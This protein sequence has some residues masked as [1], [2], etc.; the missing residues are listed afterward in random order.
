[1][2]NWQVRH[3]INT[4]CPHSGWSFEEISSD[5]SELSDTDRE[6]PHD[7][8]PSS[9]TSDEEHL[10]SDGTL[11]RTNGNDDYLWIRDRGTEFIYRK[12]EIPGGYNLCQR[13]AVRDA[14]LRPL[15]PQNNG[16]W[17]PIGD[18]TEHLAAGMS[19]PCCVSHPV[20]F[21]NY[22]ITGPCRACNSMISCGLL[23]GGKCEGS[24]YLKKYV[25][26]EVT[27]IHEKK[28]C[29]PNITFPG[30]ISREWLHYLACPRDQY[31]QPGADV[32]VEEEAYLELLKFCSVQT[33]YELLC[34]KFNFAGRLLRSKHPPASSAVCCMALH[35][36]GDG[37]SVQPAVRPRQKPL[38]LKPEFQKDDDDVAGHWKHLPLAKIRAADPTV[39][40]RLAESAVNTLRRWPRARNASS[41]TEARLAKL[42]DTWMVLPSETTGKF[43]SRSRCLARIAKLFND[44]TIPDGTAWE[45]GDCGQAIPPYGYSG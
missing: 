16:I 37:V 34:C 13:R 42:L 3:R 5:E 7:Y 15:R 29:A 26:D 10:E 8:P 20:R 32:G 11:V 14:T 45:Y 17:M 6:Y 41:R 36:N 31:Y 30:R 21:L 24:K 4:T 40:Y 43:F 22:G 1:M 19:L 39:L 35:W 33:D 23:F 28:S 18:A 2:Q 12:H 44:Y 25:W 38:K 9:H 27:F